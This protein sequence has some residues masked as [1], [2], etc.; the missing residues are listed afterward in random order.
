[1]KT[2]EQLLEEA[3]I[4]LPHWCSPE[5]TLYEGHPAVIASLGA[6]FLTVVTLG[7]AALYYWDLNHNNGT[8]SDGVIRMERS[9]FHHMGH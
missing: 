6:L 4:L 2:V 7:L 5:E 8:L 3:R 1:M 9:M